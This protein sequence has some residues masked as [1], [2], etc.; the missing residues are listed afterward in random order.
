MAKNNGTVTTGIIG[1]LNSECSSR[2]I[3]PQD[4]KAGTLSAIHWLIKDI[5]EIRII[6]YRFVG[7]GTV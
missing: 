1:K 3:V 6:K 2:N 7:W 4:I 5:E